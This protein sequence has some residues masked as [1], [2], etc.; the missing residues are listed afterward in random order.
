MLRIWDC[1]LLEGSKVLFR[2]SCG[3]LSMHQK[4]LLYQTD[5]ISIFRQLK[6]LTKY[7]FDINCLFK[8]TGILF[9]PFFYVSLSI[10]FVWFQA[11]Y[12][13]L[14]PFP[15]R[16]DIMVKQKYYLNMLSESK[17]KRELERQAFV[18]QEQMVFN[19]Y[20]C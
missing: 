10:A 11:A 1:F 15:R 7:T 16:T 2:F 14:K 12:F 5:T 3:L 6:H 19:F 18:Y 9:G 20:F 13:D 8:V 4:T 17:K